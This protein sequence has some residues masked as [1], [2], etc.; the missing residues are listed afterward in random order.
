MLGARVAGSVSAKTDFVVAG[1][2]A[3]SKRKKAE[4]LGLTIL[5]EQAWLELAEM[6]GPDRQSPVSD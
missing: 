1:P 5:N 6:T 3:G 2:G 4:E